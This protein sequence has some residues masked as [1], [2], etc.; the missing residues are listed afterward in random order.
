MISHLLL[1]FIFIDERLY[2]IILYDCV[3]WNVYE[4][5]CI[6]VS[7]VFDAALLFIVCIANV[8]IFSRSRAIIL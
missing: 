8:D 5:S 7:F 4:M 1:F 6:E 3:N 2:N